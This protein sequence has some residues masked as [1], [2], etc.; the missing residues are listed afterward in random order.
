MPILA[1]GPKRD[2][3]HVELGN[4]G[5]IMDPRFFRQYLNVLAEYGAANPAATV[6]T[7]GRKVFG[8]P[9]ASKVDT[10]AATPPVANS[11]AT[12]PGTVA[13]VD[14]LTAD[15]PK[16]NIPVTAIPPV[17]EESGTKGPRFFRKYLDMLDE[18]PVTANI[19]DNTSVT[20]DPAAKTATINTNVGGTD[21]SATR[22]LTTG[23]LDSA[24]VATKVGG[25]NIQATHDRSAIPANQMSADYQVDPNLNV[26]AKYTQAGYKGQMAPTT[27][28]TANYNNPDVGKIDARVDQGAMFQGAGK[29]VQ[30]G[31]PAIVTAKV[32][33]P[34]GQTA[35]YNTNRN[36]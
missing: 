8:A 35:T 14:Q 34:Q 31:N 24:S 7:D 11:T 2:I 12:A 19:D 13:P 10:T 21:V 32:T 23:K 15:L 29:N 16:P 33:N 9:N 17:S 25:A 18:Q 4:Q 22:N 26:G 27:Q 30:Q 28:M 1:Q 20:A 5:K 36:L 6:G 3:G